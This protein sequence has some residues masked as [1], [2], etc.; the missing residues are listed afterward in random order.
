MPSEMETEILLENCEL[1]EKRPGCWEFILTIDRLER[2]LEEIIRDADAVIPVPP[3]LDAPLLESAEIMQKNI[4]VTC[5]AMEALGPLMEARLAE[6]WGAPGQPGSVVGIERVCAEILSR[7][8][9]FADAECAILTTPMHPLFV[10]AQEKF[11][12]LASE[13][14]SRVLEIIKSIRTFIAEGHTGKL[15][16]TL[17]LTTDRVA[18]IVMPDLSAIER[19]VRSQ[20]QASSPSTPAIT[21]RRGGMKALNLLG[22]TFCLVMGLISLCGAWPL[23]LLFL[24]MALWNFAYAFDSDEN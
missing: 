10:D 3:S 16:L 15:D 19:T 13:N 2:P 9:E 24:F 7:S 14:I 20:F 4:S 17:R 5:A 8:K 12:G 22:G 1:F 18:G 6:S 23:G 11:Q 21:P